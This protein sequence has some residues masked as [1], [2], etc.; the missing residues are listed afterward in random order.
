[1]LLDDDTLQRFYDGDLSPLD[2][3]AV[4]SR[5]E[6]DPEAQKRLA[7]LS[8]MSEMFRVA[9]EEMSAD[10]GSDAL[11]A[12]I[13]SSIKQERALGTFERLRV[14]TSEWVEHKR[15]MVVPLVA[16]SAVAAAALITVLV[17]K[18]DVQL[19]GADDAAQA[20]AAGEPAADTSPHGTRIENV[21][22]GASTGTVFEIESQGVTTAVVWITDEEEVLP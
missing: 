16:T 1:M 20:T 12:S 11:F 6:A 22:F 17:P 8:R 18:H 14:V 10:L 19:E 15:G 21:D 9:A 3:R 5:V 2:A 13:Q 7:E 4:Q